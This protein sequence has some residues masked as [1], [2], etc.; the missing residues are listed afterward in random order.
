MEN[1]KIKAHTNRMAQY[2]KIYVAMNLHVSADGAMR[3]IE[4][5]WESG[6]RFSISKIL[7]VRQAPPRYVG[8]MPTV[9]YKV[10]VRGRERELY[11]EKSA[12]RWFVE[13]QVF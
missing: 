9:R 1:L 5:E 6:E 3:P 2:E 8:S 13:K 11:F 12:N 4:I 7:D 10:L